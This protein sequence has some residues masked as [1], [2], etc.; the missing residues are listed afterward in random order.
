MLVFNAK[1]LSG[2]SALI[3]CEHSAMVSVNDPDHIYFKCSWFLTE[4]R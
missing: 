3:V 1:V 4:N 2:N